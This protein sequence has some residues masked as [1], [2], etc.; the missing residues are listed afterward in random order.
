MA[1]AV[2]T[3]QERYGLK[4]LRCI[5]GSL[6]H[7]QSRCAALERQ[8]V[9]ADGTRRQAMLAALL[10]ARQREQ[11]TITALRDGAV[12]VSALVVPLHDD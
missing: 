11:E 8:L 5:A 12:H 9:G 10:E 3:Q 6:D 4:M 1:T 2:F 7:W